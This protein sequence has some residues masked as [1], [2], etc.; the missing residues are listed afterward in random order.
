M[1]LKKEAA[2]LRMQGKKTAKGKNKKGNFKHRPDRTKNEK[3]RAL[4][5]H[6]SDAKTG[7]EDILI[8]ASNH[9]DG[10]AEDS[11]MMREC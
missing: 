9:S 8:E 5:D 10:E 1:R 3:R 4:S 2:Q 6:R 11:E 7:M